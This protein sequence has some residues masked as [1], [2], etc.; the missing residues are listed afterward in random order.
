MVMSIAVIGTSAAQ[1]YMEDD[2]STQDDTKWMYAASKAFAED[3][4]LQG[5]KDAVIHQ[6]AFSNPDLGA[7]Y[8]HDRNWK[9]FVAEMDVRIVD[10]DAPGS[11]QAFGFWIRAYGDDFIDGENAGEIYNLGYDHTNSSYV[12]GKNTLQATRQNNIVSVPT[13]QWADGEGVPYH[14]L[15]IKVETSGMI[16]LWADG[17][18]V[19]EVNTADL[20]A[21]GSD[22]SIYV[23]GTYNTPVL[24]VNNNNFFQMDNFVVA[25]PDYYGG[26]VEPAPGD[27]TNVPGND[28]P[29]PGDTNTPGGNTPT[30]GATDT[31]KNQSG[32]ATTGDALYIAVA[33]A[34]AA[35]G[36]A[37]VVKKV[38]VK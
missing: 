29:A 38:N 2:F 36:T 17:V 11:T 10:N 25:S 28:T 34:V 30:P 21:T 19:L 32:A 26:A 6:S 22:N 15:G 13:E 14:K 23:M 12:I 1:I 16:S 27:D 37:I 5:Y 9:T 8:G 33:V 31:N 18:K 35:L 3:G 20:T 7:E 4:M 24:V